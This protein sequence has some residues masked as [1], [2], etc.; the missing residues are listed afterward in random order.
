MKD[1]LGNDLKIGDK[2]IFVT[3]SSKNE[4]LFFDTGIVEKLCN[5]M[6]WINNTKH[7]Y[8]QRNAKYTDRWE[9]RYGNKTIRKRDRIIKL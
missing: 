1:A 4:F 8:Y 9:N 7:K 2:V 6:V 5:I 3:C